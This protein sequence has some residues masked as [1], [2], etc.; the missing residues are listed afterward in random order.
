MQRLVSLIG[1][2]L[3]CLT[4]TIWAY[5][6]GTG[7][8]ND[9]YQIAT[10]QDLIE[11]GNVPDDYDKCF[12]LTADIDLSGYNFNQ[13][14]IAP[15][16]VG[17][18]V[19]YQGAGFSGSFD[20][21]GYVISHLKIQ[22]THYLGLFG[23]CIS[24]SSIYN[25][26]L[27]AVDVNGTGR[28]IGGLVGENIGAI[29][30]CYILG[31]VTGGW[32]VGGLVGANGNPIERTGSIALCYSDANV[33]GVS[34][35]GG[36]VG[37][38]LHAGITSSYS[39]GIVNGDEDVGGLV[40]Q[41]SGSV[42]SCYST[43]TVTGNVNVGGLIG[44][45][46]HGC[47]KSCYSAGS[48]HGGESV[49]GLV[50]ENDQGNISSSYSI[51]E[52]SGSHSLG[53]LVGVDYDG[54]TTSSF[55]NTETSN[56]QHSNG[57]IGLITNDMKDTRTYLEA[58]WDFIGEV[59][60]GTCN[61]WFIHEGAYPSLTVF[62]GYTP[63]EPNGAG[64]IEDPYLLMDVNDLGTVWY[65]PESHYR[66]INDIDLSFINWNASVIPWLGGSIDGDNHALHY[67]QVEGC[68]HLGLVGIL[69]KYATV[70]NLDLDVV[71]INGMGC[72]V[73]ALVGYNHGHIQSCSSSGDVIGSKYVG[74]LVGVGYGRIA[75]S[76]STAHTSGSQH[77]GG[78]VGYE[79]GEIRNCYSTGPVNGVDSYVGGLIGTNYG[80]ILSS[81]ST[82]VVG[83]DG[84][85]GGLVGYNNGTVRLCYSAGLTR[86]GDG[87]V[88][89]LI[90][91]SSE[92]E[93]ELC[94]WDVNTSGLISSD[95]GVGLN[96]LEMMNPE[97]L[98]LN[99]LALDPNWI[100]DSGQD[101]PRLIWEET[102]GEPIPEPSIN[103]IS[104]E[105]SVNSPYQIKTVEQ[106]MLIGK[107]S[108]ISDKCFVLIN[109]LDLSGLIWGQAIIP[110]FDGNFDG[111]GY[112]FSHLTLQGENHLGLFGR[113]ASKA[114]VRNLGLETV[115]VNGFYNVGTL[116]GANYGK[117]ESCYSKGV[118]R[119][120]WWLGGL[121]GSNQGD[122]IN[123]YSL[124]SVYGESGVVG[125]LVGDNWRGSIFNCFSAGQVVGFEGSV[126]GL[127]GY[128][129]YVISSF[130]NSETSG[131]SISHGGSGLTTTQMQDISTF[132]N[133]SWDFVDEV[134]NGTDDIWW[135]PDSDYPRLWWELSE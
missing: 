13:A 120:Y 118:V 28:Y 66:L 132:L 134:G 63:V 127:V 83:G 129:S 72:F 9:P 76:H 12:I 46:Y 25:L 88:G 57:G 23:K 11:L 131:Q 82:S 107:S 2:S 95:G 26:G 108:L 21:Q 115:D 27:E 109:D 75:A 133:A 112:T 61:Y 32:T 16:F 14:L 49:G 47:V 104:G 102:V 40:G 130:W 41:C 126:G 22:G 60:N 80:D 42:V 128:G 123:C 78:L 114:C 31:D 36:L 56:R 90:G 117:I 58:G 99:G 6:G 19:T 7:E 33:C 18:S 54:T 91:N 64:T 4:S 24:E 38:N 65:R 124:C 20:G 3:V 113:L 121:T 97:M 17:N 106:L 79:G 39:S 105:G 81:Y 100:L 1:L 59:D 10:A 84:S 52:V 85:V 110:S 5:S 43:S 93:V 34:S 74:G 73:G 101:Y 119:G 122:I 111:D 67:L 55:W 70:S 48:S 37:D 30:S 94:I 62:S 45:S 71:D 98:G 103:W 44:E 89:G 35:V 29:R 86:G 77:I 50:G 92:G 116:A 69:A 53:G 51:S 96:T 135:M 68:G 125:G 8:P 87:F 15:D